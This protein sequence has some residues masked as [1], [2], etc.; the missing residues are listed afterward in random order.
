MASSTKPRKLIPN[1]RSFHDPYLFIF[2]EAAWT[3][4]LVILSSSHALTTSWIC[5]RWSLVQLL[6]CTRSS[7][8]QL[9]FLG[10]EGHYVNYWLIT[11][12]SITLV[13][14]KCYYYYYYHY[15]Y[16]YFYYYLPS[17]F[18]VFLFGHALIIFLS[19]PYQESNNKKLS[20]VYVYMLV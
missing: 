17:Y 14:I 2:V 3:W 6:P 9:G 7:S 5:F 1:M 18:Q 12:I 13:K 19:S 4:N 10:R 16:Y 20:H 15:H 11:Y 8:C